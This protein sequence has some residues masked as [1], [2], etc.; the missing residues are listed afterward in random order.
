MVSEEEIKALSE[1]M[2]NL[3]AKG[4][5]EQL[6]AL[7]P[8]PEQFSQFMNLVFSQA[9]VLKEYEEKVLKREQGVLG[10]DA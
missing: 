4:D 1:K 3:A 6:A 9:D 7:L 8:T 5:Y 2:Q 10:A